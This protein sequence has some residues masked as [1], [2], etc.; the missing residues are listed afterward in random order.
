V[1]IEPRMLETAADVAA[2]CE[3]LA[4]E[5]VV[6]IDTEFHAEGTYFP[7]LLLVQLSTRHE[8]AFVDPVSSSL[9]TA[10]LARI[11]ETLRSHGTLLVGHALS[12]D[13]GLLL[14]VGRALPARVFDTQIAAAFLGGGAQ[15]GLKDLLATKLGV[16]LA[17]GQAMADWAR[18]PLPPKQLE[19][20]AEDV[21][22]LLPLADVLRRELAE[23]QRDAWVDEECALL[24]DPDVLAPPV[25][26]EAWTKVRRRPRE[27]TRPARLLQAL[28]AERERIAQEADLPPRWILPDE[29]LVDL[30]VR[31]PATASALREDTHRQKAPGLDRYATRW[32]AAIRRAEETAPDGDGPP[33]ETKPLTPGQRGLLDLARLLVTSVAEE[34]G[35]AP[36]LLHSCVKETLPDLLPSAPADRAE[37]VARLGISGWRA[38]LVGDSLWALVSGT[39]RAACVED[40]DGLRLRWTNE[41]G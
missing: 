32:L 40:E 5:P 9:R 14:R 20:A 4:H 38:D 41:T 2:F 22:H 37:L 11:L 25:P 12:N 34:A 24:L 10:D 1:S 8:I 28:A 33:R 16:E 36:A 7:R 3:R 39:L 18:R 13:L 29:R 6:G 30:A 17:K 19:Y 35:L 23:R 15:V 31:A 27:G 21:R 26:D